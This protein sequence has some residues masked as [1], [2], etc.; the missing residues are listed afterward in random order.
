MNEK[1]L[2]KEALRA[3]S[4][5]RTACIKLDVLYVKHKR[6]SRAIKSQK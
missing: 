6:A 5:L 4:L 2:Q 1:E 3:L